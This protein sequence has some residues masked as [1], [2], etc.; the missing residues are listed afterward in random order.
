M[1]RYIKNNNEQKNTHGHQSKKKTCI[2]YYS[3]AGRKI[4][5]LIKRKSTNPVKCR[6][7]FRNTV[8]GAIKWCKI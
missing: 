8:I 6:K 5:N 4:I 2:L 1:Q 3:L 7:V